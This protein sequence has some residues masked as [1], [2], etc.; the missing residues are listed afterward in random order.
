MAQ[1]TRRWNPGDAA[2]TLVRVIL[3][4]AGAL[5]GGLTER[6]WGATVSWFGG[7]CAYTGEALADGQME[8]DHAVPMNRTHCGLHLYGNVLPSTKEAN[9]QKGGKSYREFVCDPGKLEMIESFLRQSGYW[10]R[11]SV[12]GDIQRYFEAQ[13]R[14]VEALCRVNKRYLAS[15]LPEDLDDGLGDSESLDSLG[16]GEGE[17]NVL[18]IT[19][20]PPDRIAFRD[21]LL[22]SREARI[23]EVYRDGRTVARRWEARK[24]SES[25][26][27]VGNL[28]SRP[29]YRK[30]EWKRRGIESLIVAVKQS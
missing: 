2:N 22:R 23:L 13:Y 4:D 21:A 19:L 18:P 10:E 5:L 14:T 7:R 24:M 27:V 6:E 20:D 30:G 8:R 12:F 25:S 17:G 29:R 3:S 15:L 16:V 28:R 26:N 9:Q 11:V 1:Q